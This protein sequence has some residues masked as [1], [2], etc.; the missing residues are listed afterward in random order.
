M[1]GIVAI[2]MHPLPHE[3]QRPLLELDMAFGR[4][5]RGRVRIP[6]PP[7]ITH[8]FATILAAIS[9]ILTVSSVDFAVS[10]DSAA[11]IRAQ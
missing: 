9:T 6:P 4:R 3:R 11:T 8:V 5:L 10:P 2:T 1:G 7:N